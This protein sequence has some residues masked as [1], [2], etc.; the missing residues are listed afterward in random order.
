MYEKHIIGTGKDKIMKK[1]SIL[2]K[3]KQRLCITS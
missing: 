3:I 1:N 2:W